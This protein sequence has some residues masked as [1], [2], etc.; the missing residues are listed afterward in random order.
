MGPHFIGHTL[1]FSGNIYVYIDRFGE[2]ETPLGRK[3]TPLGKKETLLGEKVTICFNIFLDLAGPIKRG[4]RTGAGGAGP[5][6]GARKERQE[7]VGGS[8]WDG[9][10]FGRERVVGLA[11][12]GFF[13]GGW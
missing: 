7:L 1:Y 10:W 2:K 9:G 4:R 6:Q 8:L 5:S 3:E 12:L 13:G 11:G